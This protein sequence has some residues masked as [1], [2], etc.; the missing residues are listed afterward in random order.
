MQH[1]DERCRRRTE[2]CWN[3]ELVVHGAGVARESMIA[4][5]GV[6]PMDSDAVRRILSRGGRMQVTVGA[7]GD[8]AVPAF[9]DASGR[10]GRFPG[11]ICGLGK[12]AA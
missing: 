4:K 7:I 5:L 6:A 11:V 10:P 3:E 9:D 1:Y 8:N 12:V 2:A